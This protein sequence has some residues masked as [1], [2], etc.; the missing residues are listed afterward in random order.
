LATLNQPCRSPGTGNLQ[1]PQFAGDL[2]QGD[3]AA[4]FSGFAGSFNHL[5]GSPEQHLPHGEAARFCRG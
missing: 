2:S 4:A 3:R 5:G 1:H